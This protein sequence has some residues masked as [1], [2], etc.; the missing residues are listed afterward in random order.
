MRLQS[1]GNWRQDRRWRHHRRGGDFSKAMNKCL[2]L[3]WPKEMEAEKMEPVRLA[4]EVASAGPTNACLHELA[5]F[6]DPKAG[7]QPFKRSDDYRILEAS[8]GELP[9]MIPLAYRIRNRIE[10]VHCA[11]VAEDAARPRF[12]ADDAKNFCAIMFHFK[13]RP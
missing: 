2:G 9:I 7:Y 6:A 5:P 4:F 8:D 11:V 12:S 3:D 13:K 1:F 10:E